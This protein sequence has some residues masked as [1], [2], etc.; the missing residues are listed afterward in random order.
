MDTGMRETSSSPDDVSRRDALRL[1][2]GGLAAGVLAVGAA[3]A[4]A[5][6]SQPAAPP[7]RRPMKIVFHVS[8]SDGWPP[9]FSNVKNMA[10]QHPQAK[11]RV[12][13]D[14]GGVYLL[15][16]PND[17]TPLFAKYAAAGVEFQACHN[18]LDEKK[19]APASLPPGVRVVPA[20]VVALA[21]SQYEGYAYIKP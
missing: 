8:D 10:A 3:G 15:P 11:L 13:V 7:A 5:Q 1:G 20:G 14:G 19:I 12:V 17:L 4:E 16:G 21:D 9:A 18:A 2:A 6:T